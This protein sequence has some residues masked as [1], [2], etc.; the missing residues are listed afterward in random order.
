[1]VKPGPDVCIEPAL[2]EEAVFRCFR[3]PAR[4]S[5]EWR[6]NQEREEVYLLPAVERSA[7]FEALALRWFRRLGLGDALSACLERVP[8]VRAGLREV[9]LKRARGPR[10]EGS[11]LFHGADGERLV[12]VLATTRFGAGL[13]AFLLHELL[14]AED[15]LDPAFAYRAGLGPDL[16]PGDPRTELVRDRLRALWEL[17]LR[18]RV[19]RLLGRARVVPPLGDLERAFAGWDADELAALAARVERGEL[20]RFPELL[21]L[22]RSQPVA[23]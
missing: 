14:R 8:H 5:E 16:A 1:M 3:G 7:A 2:A 9:R 17:R 12:L 11:E 15:M 13:E 23:L 18:G 20:A 22:A 6:W 21:E 19:A 10:A 4:S